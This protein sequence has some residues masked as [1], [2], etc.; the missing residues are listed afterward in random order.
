VGPVPPI[1]GVPPARRPINV[2]PL[3]RGLPPGYIAV[4]PAGY[5]VAVIRGVR[6]YFAG[7][8]YY[9]PQFYQGRT[10]YVRVKL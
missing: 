5:R 2:P 6:Y 8:V 4:L 3:V 9:R 10:Y 1:A 7:G